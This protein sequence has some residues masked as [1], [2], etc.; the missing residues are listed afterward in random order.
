MYPITPEMTQEQRERLIEL[1]KTIGS[2]GKGG[3]S[4]EYMPIHA[5]S[6]IEEANPGPKVEIYTVFG[7]PA[8][9]PALEVE[10]DEAS[11]IAGLGNGE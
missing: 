2:G 3:R 6:V 1:L 8:T 5:L 9:N 11:H 10:H 7:V 4:A